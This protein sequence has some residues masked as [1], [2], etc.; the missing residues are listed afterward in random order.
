MRGGALPG[1]RFRS[2]PEAMAE[3]SR[4]PRVLL[5]EDDPDLAWTY[6]RFLR[7]Q[8]VALEHAASGRAALARL[9][10]A[11]P[12]IVLLDLG[13]P[14][15]D[16]RR[17]LEH[18]VAQRPAPVIL[19]I[20]G[21]ASIDVAVRALQ[22]GAHDFLAK[23]IPAERLV[24]TV[25][26]AL[27][28][29]RLSN[30]VEVYRRDFA[31]DRFHGFVGGSLAMQAVYRIVESA[32]RSTA[33]VF[34]TGESGTGKEL[35]ARA[36]HACSP[37]RDKPFIALNCSA[38]PRD[39]MESELFGH[40]KGAFT[41]AIGARAGAARLAHGGSLFLDEICELDRGLQAKLLRFV[42]FGSVQPV[43][44]D[45]AV[46]VDV[47][48]ICATNRDPLREVEAGRCRED[49]YYRLHV[50]PI[51]LP[52]L[53]E[54]EDDILGLA[55]H[56]LESL[57]REEGKGFQ[58]IAPMAEAVLASYAWPGNVRQLENVIRNIVVL[59][60]GPVVQREMLPPPLDGLA[61][62]EQ[63]PTARIRS[64]D[65]RNGIRPLWQAERAA[66]EEALERC[67]GNV[68]EAAALLQISPSTIYRKR[69][70][71]G[72]RSST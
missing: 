67:G 70:A 68:A 4:I 51:H 60:E 37:R 23:P 6:A 11:P 9:E 18:L 46:R 52:P 45:Q 36:I 29:H 12:A 55:Y 14:D 38:I 19:V 33:T 43:G 41:G 62:S 31:R 58:S 8:P 65:G 61:V 32:A 17:L 7:D 71:W 30:L 26:N 2:E 24:V 1:S 72:R 44:G 49:L 16:G 56:F 40:A 22:A 10:Q 63:A 3:T 13:L 59:H 15:M 21:L 5:V 57:G 25:R 53:R 35:C 42:Q 69:E 47:R 48:L 64:A 28:R 50:V 27:E 20:T 66:I 34:I 39:L 54:R